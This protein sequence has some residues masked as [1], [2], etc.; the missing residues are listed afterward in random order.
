MKLILSQFSQKYEEWKES[1]PK[2]KWIEDITPNSDQMTAFRSKLVEIRDRFS[3]DDG[4]I[5]IFS[6]N[7]NQ[8]IGLF[9]EWVEE[10][11]QQRQRSLGES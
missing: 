4:F 5:A 10:A 9:R 6:D 3:A 1:L 2:F 11:K 7:M 8:K